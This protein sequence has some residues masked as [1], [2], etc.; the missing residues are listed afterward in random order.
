MVVNFTDY[1]GR[2]VHGAR[3]RA[4]NCRWSSCAECTLDSH[5]SYEEYCSLYTCW[6]YERYEEEPRFA[7]K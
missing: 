3:A 4:T 7:G 6:P 5:C 2:L 1:F